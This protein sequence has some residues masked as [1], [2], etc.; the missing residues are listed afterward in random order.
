MGVHHLD[1]EV[2]TTVPAFPLEVEGVLDASDESEVEALEE[3]LEIRFPAV[4]TSVETGEGLEDIGEFLYRALKVVRVYTKV[5]G[6]PPDAD[7]PFTVLQGATVHDVA[8]LVHK[9]I[10]GGLLRSHLGG[11][12]LR[13]PA[14]RAG[15][16][17]RGP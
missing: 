13:R 15:S 6:K 4:R 12:C 1:P 3:L 9:D 8:R 14:G 2:S 7:R 17:G 11:Q 10:A 16:P 5:P